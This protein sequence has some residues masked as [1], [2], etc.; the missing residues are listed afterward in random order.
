[1][2][3][4]SDARSKKTQQKFYKHVIL[5]KDGDFK[6]INGDPCHPTSI[7]MS[8]ITSRTGKAQ[9]KNIEFAVNMSQEMV[10]ARLEEEYPYLSN[11]R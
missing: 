1:M 10:K 4:P 6:W 3:Y 11:R 7:D 8:K 9:R 2:A 5:L